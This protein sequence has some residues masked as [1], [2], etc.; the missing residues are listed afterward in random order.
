[1]PS[2]AASRSATQ[3]AFAILLLSLPGATGAEEIL[4]ITASSTNPPAAA[5]TNSRA[6][7]LGMCRPAGRAGQVMRSLLDRSNGGLRLVSRRHP[8]A[9]SDVKYGWPAT[10]GRC[11]RPA[12]IGLDRALRT[13]SSSRSE[14]RTATQ[15]LGEKSMGTAIRHVSVRVPWHDCAWDGQVCNDPLANASSLA[16]KLV[17]ENRNDAVDTDLAGSGIR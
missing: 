12:E 17:A 3:P 7:L 2:A 8:L 1:M 11:V 5:P 14:S 4:T 16:L 10:D 9:E 6:N 15:F 13:C